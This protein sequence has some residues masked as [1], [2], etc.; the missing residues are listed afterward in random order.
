MPEIKRQF[1]GGAMNKDLDERLVPSDQYR[2]ALNIQVASS[3]GSDMGTVQNVLGNRVPYA[4]EL[5]NLGS[6]AICIGSYIDTKTDKI[7]WFIGSDTKSLILEFNQKTSLVSPIL[8]DTTGV[9]NFNSTYLITGI[10]IIDNLLF[11]TDNQTEPKKINIDDWRGYNNSNSNYTHTQV[12]GSNFI[13]D[14]ITMIKKAPIKPPSLTMAP[15]KR[16]GI[17]ETTLLQK[18]FTSTTSP[19]EPVDTGDYGNVTF[20]T[21]PN[22]QV[23]DKLRATLLDESNDEE[24]ILSV[25]QVISST[26][27]KLNLDVVAEDI[28]EGNQNWKIVLMEEKAMF[29][30]KFPKFAYRYKYKDGEYS[31]IGPYTPVAF[32]PSDFDYAPKKGYN[33]GMVNTLRS[34]KIGGFT[35][36]IPP[37]VIEV[38]ILYKENSNQN[39]YTIQSIKTSDP[40]YTAGTNGE[41]EITSET[42]Y[43]VLPSLQALRPWDNVPI[44]AKAQAMSANRIM[45]GNYV[46]NFNMK[47]TENNDISVKFNVSIIQ[48]PS[49]PAL[50]K[51]PKPSLKSLRTYQVGVVYRDKYGRET[52]VFTDPSGSFILDK[53]ASINY[54]VLRVKIISSIPSWAESY[55]YF[56]KES[57]DEYYNLAMDRHYPAEDG[58]VWIAFPSSERNKVTDETF[59]V[60]KKKHNSDVFVEDE[61]RYKI[62]AI[63]NE[64]PE[65]LKQ[66]KV[67]K[68]V[69]SASTSGSS[70]NIFYLNDGYPQKDYMHVHVLKTKWTKVFGGADSG[71]LTQT[72]VHTLSDLVMRVIGNGNQSKYYNVANIQYFDTGSDNTRYF[73]VEIEDKF[74]ESDISFTGDY[75]QSDSSLSL[76]IAQKTTKT[77]P[78]F[79]GRFFAKIQRDG[80]LESAI[81]SQENVDDW[82]VNAST[83]I[84][85]LS[86][87]TA[88][89]NYWQNTTKGSYPGSDAHARSAEWFICRNN[90]YR[91]ADAGGNY[92][93]GNN[94]YRGRLAS[95]SLAKSTQGFGARAGNSFMEVAYHWFGGEDRDAW[96]NGEPLWYNFEYEHKPQYKKIV[97]SLQQMNMKFRFSDDPDG[98]VYTIKAYRRSHIVTYDRGTG[99]RGKFSSER[100]IKWTL[101][102]DKAIVWAPEDNGKTSKSAATTIEFLDV[103]ASGDEKG[104]T[105]DNPAIFET[106]PK[107]MVDLN[108][109]YEASQ[110]YNKSLHGNDQT[111][112]YSNCF[113]FANGVE[114]DRIRDDFN[115]SKMGKGVK[116]S[117]VLDTPYEEERKSNQVIFSGIYNSVSGINNTNQFIQADQITKSLNP[118]YGPIQLMRHRHGGL[119]VLCQDKCFKLPTNKDIL[120]TGDGS[121]QV[122]VSSK[123]LGTAVPYTGEFGISEQP[124][125]YTTYGYRAY[126]ADKARGVVLR[127][128]NDGLEP[129]SRYGMERYF[130][131]NLSLATTIIGSYDE[132]KKEYNITFNNDTLS[133]KENNNGWVS[134]KSFL[135]E[136]GVTLNNKYYTFKNGD[137]W[138]HDNETR[139]TFYDTNYRYNSSSTSNFE[140][141]KVKFIFNDA[142][143]SVKSFKTL[144]YEGSKARIFQDNSGNADTDNN[145][146]NKNNVSGWWTNSIESDKQSGQILSYEEKEGKW[147]NYIQ[148]TQST[149]SNLDTSE[150]S[151][152]GIG[153]AGTS[154]TASSDYSYKVTITVNENND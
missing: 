44:K 94:K 56:I 134:R 97:D 89:K 112:D 127:L 21:A 136:D 145:F 99:R 52:P 95:A 123:V 135:Q 8:V 148:G 154:V 81:L 46:E 100:V 74:D 15:S 45:Y 69:L 150:F 36:S 51:E 142:P 24:A 14:H 85:A 121:K 84:Y 35:E 28:D 60:L 2:D 144:N 141:S 42:V 105:S 6:N 114:S 115:A 59:L 75:N 1:G 5:S 23:G 10:N 22:F 143:G 55:K 27:F 117:T 66:D 64:A 153:L 107:E 83:N 128:S 140:P 37:G 90:Y 132:N 110:A 108:L 7:Y 96:R 92:Q 29:E 118:V 67:S 32:L 102:L 152:Q 31:A 131:D 86:G 48:N 116:A 130:K 88:S 80:V 47:D 98:T 38:D 146:Y 149:L 40:E 87:K 72:P 137:L 125:S 147:F 82:K 71:N 78:E 126:F 138:I 70:G 19:F 103:Y 9:L 54:N 77:E 120:F 68:G 53:S 76:E 62:I 73:R 43:K 124:E 119:D 111:L 129:I 104:F 25:T 122:T 3:E 61:A 65:F 26:V 58:N 49:T 79:T 41:V 93:T 11:W 113:S 16:T 109:Y 139:N 133:F 20:S 4:S 151:V 12:S 30:F 106:E 50:A 33:L 18:S 63:E 57:S 39:I 17:V 34:L 91:Y 13:E 101:K